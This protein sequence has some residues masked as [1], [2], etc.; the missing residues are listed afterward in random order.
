[1]N[2]EILALYGS[3][4]QRGF[5]SRM[6]DLFYESFVPDKY[7]INKIYISDLKI[8]GCTACESCRETFACV[9]DD[10][11]NE[12]YPLLKDASLISVAA[13]VYFSGL[14]GPLKNLIDRCQVIWELSMR[15]PGE[16]PEKE[17]ILFSAAGS[18]YPGSFDG[19]YLTVRHFFDTDG[20]TLKK[21]NSFYLPDTDQLTGIPNSLEANITARARELHRKFSE[22]HDG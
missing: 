15:S 9:L 3:P 20:A 12:L 5:S 17:G 4:R 7:S 19:V 18:D 1:M 14:P 22:V 11:M 8:L 21:E 16:I 2:S 6:Q 10:D 13:P